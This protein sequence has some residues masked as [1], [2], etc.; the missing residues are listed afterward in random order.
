MLCCKAK[1][2]RKLAEV[3][4]PLSSYLVKKYYEKIEGKNNLS[5]TE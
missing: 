1:E 5:L 3:L 4:P 2:G